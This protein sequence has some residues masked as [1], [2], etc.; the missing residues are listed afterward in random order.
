[1]KIDRL[2]SIIV[3][4]LNKNNI[5]AKELA[6][7]FEV[8]LRTIYR[9][10]ETINLAGIPIV[11]NQGRD[12]GF[13]ILDNYKMSHQLLT[14]DDMASIV[15]AL[16]NIENF[17]HNKDIDLTID[18]ISNI[19]PRDKREEFD[20]YFNELIICDLPWGYRIDSGD[21]EKYNIIYEGIS[22]EKLLYIGYRNRDGNITERRIEP[23]SLVLKGLNWYVFSYCLL[24]NGYRFF[25]LS[26]IHR[27]HLLEEG[28]NRREMSYEEFKYKSIPKNNMVDLVLKFS[29]KVRQRVEEFFYEEDITIDEDGSIIVRTSFPEDEWVYSMILSYGEYIEVIEPFY[30]KDIIKKKSRK[31]YEKY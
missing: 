20:Y 31:I 13:R 26:R 15:I 27:I 10:I 28:F 3:I 5:T 30:I 7:R 22:K 23:M 12:G 21:K 6:N 2:L 11:S 18:K 16:K 29:S 17:S 19:V 8:S 14:L 25:K 1:M 4:L 9:D 24:R